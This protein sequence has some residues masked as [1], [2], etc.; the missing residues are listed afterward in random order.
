VAAHRQVLVKINAL[1]DDGIAP[2]IKALN[3]IPWVYTLSSCQGGA[4]VTF[5]IAADLKVQAVFLCWLS[6]E[7]CGLAELAAEWGGGDSLVFTIRCP[8]T[9]QTIT[10]LAAK[11]SQSSKTFCAWLDGNQRKE[12]RSSPNLRFHRART[13]SC[14]APANLADLMLLAL[15][16]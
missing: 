7:I 14:D 5:R 15:H 8:P 16:S 1:V 10:S 4:F 3:Q 11:M 12:S 13:A 2:L 9:P 6:R